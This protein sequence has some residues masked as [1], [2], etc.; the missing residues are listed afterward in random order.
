MAFVICLKVF[1]QCL[2][3]Q[4]LMNQKLIGIFLNMMLLKSWVSFHTAIEDW[5]MHKK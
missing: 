2:E 5:I 3:I 4:R 1:V